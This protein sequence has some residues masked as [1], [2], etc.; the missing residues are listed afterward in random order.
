MTGSI[1][2]LRVGAM[3]LSL[4]LMGVLPLAA[5]RMP[6]GGRPQDRQDLEQ[7]V[8]ARFAENMRRR[9]GLTVDQAGALEAVVG[10]LQADR[11]ALRRD[12]EALRR[13]MEVILTDEQSTEQEA[14]EV[15]QRMAELRLR[16]ARLFQD[17]QEQLLGILTPVQVV[18]FHAMR[19]QLAARIQQLRGGAPGPGRRPGGM[20]GP[21][22]F[23]P[24]GF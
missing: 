21:P 15:L 13:R 12:E 14:A 19:E 23:L 5:Q 11:M 10:G 3:V 20:D 7:R 9:L 8:R 4:G 2:R 1:R 6:G 22:G 18:R 17:E 16:E 24:P